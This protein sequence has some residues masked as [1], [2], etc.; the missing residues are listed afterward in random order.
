MPISSRLLRIGVALSSLALG[1]PVA[2]ANVRVCQEQAQAYEQIARAAGPIEINN[3]L[4]AA[5]DK[6][7]LE[8]AR[9]FS[10]TAPRWRRATAS[11]AWRSHARPAPGTPTSSS[12]S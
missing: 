9:N 5:A 4:W 1:A 3:A 6:G 2:H 10:T 11:A 12:C 8:L 7:C